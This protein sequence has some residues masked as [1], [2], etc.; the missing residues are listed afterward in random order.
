MEVSRLV[1]KFRQLDNHEERVMARARIEGA[2]ALEVV[3]SY[4]AAQVDAIDKELGCT[5]ALYS[6][7]GDTHLYVASLLA[8]REANMKLLLL[9]TEKIE[10][11]VDQTK[12]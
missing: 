10:L 1:K 11:D 9:L 6:Q 3:V 2:E 5:K 4:L 8:K 12:E 7:Q